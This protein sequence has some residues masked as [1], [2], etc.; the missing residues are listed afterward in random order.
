MKALTIMAIQMIHRS[1]DIVMHRALSIARL[2]ERFA[3]GIGRVLYWMK[4]NRIQLNLNK[5]ECLWIH[6]TRCSVATIPDLSVG[7][8]TIHPST[9]AKS[10]GVYFDDHLLYERQVGCCQ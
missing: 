1:M 9:S 2:A 7:G 4:V 5:T 10:L 3:L 6:S 8:V